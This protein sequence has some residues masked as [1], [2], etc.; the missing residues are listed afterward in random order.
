MKTAIAWGHLSTLPTY[1]QR[2]ALPKV[3]RTH[4]EPLTSEQ[5]NALVDAAPD[6]WKSAVLLLFTAAP[7]RAELFGLRLQD[8]DLEAGTV[9]IRFQL[10]RGR[11]VEPKSESAIR[12][13]V[14]PA[15]TVEALRL[16]VARVPSNELGLLF[17]SE[18]GLP[19][20]AD[21]WFKRVWVPTREKAGL[22]HLR[23]HDARHHVASLLLSQHHS[24]K[25]VQ[26]ML[27]HATASLLLDV[28]ASVTKQG[29]DEAAIDLDRWL[30]EEERALYVANRSSG[31]TGGALRRRCRALAA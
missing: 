24:V 2:L 28:Y 22:P 17:P 14:L 23:V 18:F 11:L 5:V 15:K 16:H 9:T 31:V 26:R 4:F 30:G 12:K 1:G 8:L 25:L 19:V 29:E 7:R 3:R 27:G 20:D 10:Q 6:Y 13:V 21:N